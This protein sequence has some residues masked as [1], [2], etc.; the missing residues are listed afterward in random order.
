MRDAVCLARYATTLSNSGDAFLLLF[1][2]AQWVNGGAFE[3]DS[4]LHAFHLDT[5]CWA[6]I[7]TPVEIARANRP[8]GEEMYCTQVSY[9][10]HF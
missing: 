4:S 1:G 3:P 7:V 6:K 5:R 8:R 9:S 2:G 10:K